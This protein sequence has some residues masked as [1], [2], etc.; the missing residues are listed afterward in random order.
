M[1]YAAKVDDNQSEI[2]KALRKA[3]AVVLITSQLKNAFDLLVGY[4][5][6]LF[7]VEIKDG[8][9]I[10]SKRKLTEGEQKCKDNFN[11]VGVDYHIVKN[12]KEAI[13]LIN[14]S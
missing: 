11:S 14:K 1:R 12:I 8:N 7:I 3:G 9:K 2:V 6:N 10:P 4:R 13:E 5:G